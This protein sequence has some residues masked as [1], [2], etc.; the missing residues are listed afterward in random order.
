MLKMFWYRTLPKSTVFVYWSSFD[1]STAATKPAAGNSKKKAAASVKTAAAKPTT[2]DL[3]V[4][5]QSPTSPLEDISWSPRSPPRPSMCGADSLAPH[6]HLLP[7]HGDSPPAD[8]L[9]D[10]YSL[11]GRIWQHALGGR[12]GVKPYA[13]HAGMLTECA[14]E[15]LSW[16]TF[17]ASM[18]S[19]F[20]S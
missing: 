4:P 16:S 20:V 6:V 5:I 8:C 18:V 13:S 15:S 10:R 12:Y 11:R 9:E 14:A 17:S 2:P 19:I 1:K 3:V 7:P